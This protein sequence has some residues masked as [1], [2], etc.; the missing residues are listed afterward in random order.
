MVNQNRILDPCEPGDV[1]GDGD[2]D[3]SDF[4]FMVFCFH[5]PGVSYTA[6]TGPRRPACSLADLDFD[7]DVDASD[8][9]AFQS[10][11]TGAR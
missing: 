5:G 6:Q 4:Q 2:V 7:D 10:Y 11:F 3:L 9:V 8:V 1:D